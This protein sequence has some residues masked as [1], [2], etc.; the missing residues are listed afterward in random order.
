MPGQLPC[1]EIDIP[2]LRP[3]IHSDD[4]DR[5]KS[6]FRPT[7]GIMKTSGEGLPNMGKSDSR[8][9]E[10]GVSMSDDEKI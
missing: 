2:L 6:D 7:Q 5:Y 4:P 8:Q 10:Q 3:I 9:D 1:E